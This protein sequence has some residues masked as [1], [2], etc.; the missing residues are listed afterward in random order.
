MSEV[1]GTG[2]DLIEPDVASFIKEELDTEDANAIEDT[3]GATSDFV[4]HSVQVGR[5][6]SRREDDLADVALVDH[7]DE[8]VRGDLTLRVA[9]DHQAKLFFQ[10]QAPLDIQLTITQF[11]Q[12]R[13]NVR[14]LID[15]G[16]TT[17]ILGI[18][19]RLQ[20]QGITQLLDGYLDVG[21]AFW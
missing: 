10:V 21:R 7:L 5:D 12:S 19:A 14:W 13:F 9:G 8:R 15:T 17:A 1:V 16:V 18:L 20:N 3:D 11:S 4:S 2:G 6:G